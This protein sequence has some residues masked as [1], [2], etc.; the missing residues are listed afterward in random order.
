MQPIGGRRSSR[1]DRWSTPRPVM[2]A[3]KP[4]GARVSNGQAVSMRSVKSRMAF[5]SSAGASMAA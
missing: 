1:A 3:V 2:S 5:A 4:P